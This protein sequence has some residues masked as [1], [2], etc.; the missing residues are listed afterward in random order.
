MLGTAACRG[1]PLPVLA[2]VR[3]YWCALACACVRVQI[4]IAQEK[5]KMMDREAEQKASAKQMQEAATKQ[6]LASQV[7]ACVRVCL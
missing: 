4:K 7:C 3:V 2:C 1:Q 5:Q 6:R